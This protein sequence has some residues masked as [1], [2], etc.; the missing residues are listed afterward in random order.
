MISSELL[1]ILACPV[2]VRGDGEPAEGRRRGELEVADDQGGLRCTQ[3][4][5]V[6]PVVDGIPVMLVDEARRSDE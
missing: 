5:L 6:Y 2:C 1:D 4:G 3:C